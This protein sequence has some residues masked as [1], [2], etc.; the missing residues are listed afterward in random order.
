MSCADTTLRL[1]YRFRWCGDLRIKCGALYHHG[2]HAL[3]RGKLVVRRNLV[4]ET[5]SP[6]DFR[7]HTTC[8]LLV[9]HAIP[10]KQCRLA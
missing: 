4:M 7:R 1:A 6:G 8:Q 3:N 10:S 9:L 5:Y 2:K